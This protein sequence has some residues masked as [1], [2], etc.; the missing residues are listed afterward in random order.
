MHFFLCH[1]LVGEQPFECE[2][3]DKRFKTLM[4]LGKHI[5]SRYTIVRDH[6]CSVCGKDFA[7]KSVLNEHML[8]H[9]GERPFSC[10]HCDKSFTGMSRLREH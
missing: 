9:T 1:I 5:K 2:E 8:L 6:L 4:T 3:C 7:T 10:E